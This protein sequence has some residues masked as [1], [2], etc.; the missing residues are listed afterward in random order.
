MK[1]IAIVGFGTVGAGVGEL[2]KQNRDIITKRAGEEIN[3]KYI[4]DLRDFPESEFNKIRVDDYNVIVNDPE[5]DTVVETMGGCGVAY[6]LTKAS[7]SLGK[8]VVT[9]NKELVATYGDELM[10]LAK[11]NGCKYLF[12]ASVGGTIPVLR[13]LAQCLA[14]NRIT[15]IAGIVNGTTNFILT[16]MYTNGKSYEEALKEAQA[17]GYAEQNPDADVKGKDTCRK[18]T[19]LS[20]IMSGLL[21]DPE[22]VPTKGIDNITKTDVEAAEA[23]G[24]KLKLLGVAKKTENG[25]T[26]AEVSPYFISQSSPLFGIEDVFNGVLVTGDACGDV[27]FYGRGAGKMPTASAVVADVID[28]T[29]HRADENPFLPWTK[30]ADK[31]SKDYGEC[32][33]LT[34]CNGDFDSCKAQH[35]ATLSDGKY[36]FITPVLSEEKLGEYIS[37]L[38]K[39]GNAVVSKYRVFS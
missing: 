19:I 15:K 36:C 12:E 38:E 20:A 7:L 10:K 22:T 6:K 35:K 16:Q 37:D 4:C 14:A 9:S 31:P 8:N 29:M 24:G 33:Y 28:I 18:I 25:E 2:L 1:N 30:T 39:A 5:I 32:A 3:I 23:L 21:F 27:M 13:P 26:F 34:V 17:L 11:E